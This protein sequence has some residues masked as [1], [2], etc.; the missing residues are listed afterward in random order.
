MSQQSEIRPS[1]NSNVHNQS[2]GLVQFKKGLALHRLRH[3]V[4]FPLQNNEQAHAELYFTLIF[5][6]SNNQEKELQFDVFFIMHNFFSS[7]PN[8]VMLL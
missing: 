7:L 1:L 5:L 6:K 8:A 2:K 4:R 3:N